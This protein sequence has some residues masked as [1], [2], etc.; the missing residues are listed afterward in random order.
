M[1]EESWEIR[2]WLIIIITTTS[3]LLYIAILYSIF[4]TVEKMGKNNAMPNQFTMIDC[5][6]HDYLWGNQWR[7]IFRPNCTLYGF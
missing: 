4:H 3:N 1:A 2:L 6:M 7:K 5:T